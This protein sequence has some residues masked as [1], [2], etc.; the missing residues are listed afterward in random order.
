[1]PLRGGESGGP[2]GWANGLPLP[3][4]PLA[5]EQPTIVRYGVLLLLALGA[6]IAYL[7]RIGIY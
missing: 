3:R 2:P 7:N 6:T 5:G 1:M 4:L